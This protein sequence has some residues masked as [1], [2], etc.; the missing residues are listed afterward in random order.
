MFIIF[1]FCFIEFVELKDGKV[2]TDDVLGYSTECLK[3]HT[4]FLIISRIKKKIHYKFFN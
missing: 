3:E 4:S 1:L 2:Y